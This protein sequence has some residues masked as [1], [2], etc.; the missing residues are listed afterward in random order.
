MPYLLCAFG[1]VSTAIRMIMTQCA[2]ATSACV[3][4]S[5]LTTVMTCVLLLNHSV[6]KPTLKHINEQEMCIWIHSPQISIDNPNT[7]NSLFERT[8]TLLAYPSNLAAPGSFMIFVYVSLQGYIPPYYNTT[9]NHNTHIKSSS[10]SSF[11][12]FVLN[13]AP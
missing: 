13:T 11:T 9:V 6:L 2:P 1:E 5:G 8:C 4:T 3:P 7:T 10:L 12:C